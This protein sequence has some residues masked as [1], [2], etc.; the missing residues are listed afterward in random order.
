MERSARKQTVIP[1][2]MSMFALFFFFRT[3]GAD[4]VRWVQI[5][6]LFVAGILAGVALA[7]FFRRGRQSP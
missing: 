2:V 7:G 3:P 4:T 1:L 5:L 6:L